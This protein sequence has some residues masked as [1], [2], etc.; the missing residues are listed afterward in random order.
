MKI[1]IRQETS[2]D[3]DAVEVLLISAFGKEDE[4]R[5]VTKLRHS[6]AFIPALSLVAEVDNR[7]LG[8]ILL[9]KVKVKNV[10]NE[11]DSL[12]LAPV[13]I[14]PEY[15]KQGIGS[16]LIIEGLKRAKALGNDSV[17]VWGHK[18][19]YPKFGFKPALDYDILCPLPTHQ[20]YLMALA[21]KPDGLKNVSGKVIY[22]KEF[23]L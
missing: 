22:P 20:D 13:A 9:T 4:A 14:V 10:D 21:L 16:Q 5:L 2:N 8:Y 7:I 3:F 15:Q 6:E 18:E 12:A 23:G 17:I 19:Y 11:Y 1:D